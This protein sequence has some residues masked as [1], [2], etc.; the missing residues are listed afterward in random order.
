MSINSLIS[1]ELIRDYLNKNE[2]ML[3]F[4]ELEN[5]LGEII[6]KYKKIEI[7]SRIP[8]EMQEFVL[9]HEMAHF[10]LILEKKSMVSKAPYRLSKRITQHK[11]IKEIKELEAETV[12]YVTSYCLKEIFPERNKH[13]YNQVFSTACAYIG[14]ENLFPVWNG[15]HFGKCTPEHIQRAFNYEFAYPVIFSVNWI[16]SEIL[17]I[18]KNIYDFSKTSIRAYFCLFDELKYKDEKQI[19]I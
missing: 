18:S 7:D 12:A 10:D 4:S 14:S 5:N 19:L 9:Y 16:L 15:L 17:N 1:I 6:Y 11:N 8:I 13:K 2:W 3:C